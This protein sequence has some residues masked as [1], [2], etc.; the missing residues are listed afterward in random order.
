MKK[1]LFTLLFL[2]ATCTAFAADDPYRDRVLDINASARQAVAVTPSDTVDIAIV[3]R[4]GLFVGVEGDIAVIMADGSDAVTFK[5]V[6]GFIPLMV[7][8]VLVTGTTAQSIVAL[9]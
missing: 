3:P 5:S 8:R 1:F 9:Y 7:K 2:A 4:G 6:V